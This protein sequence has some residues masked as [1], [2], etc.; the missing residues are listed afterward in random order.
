MTAR[1]ASVHAPLPLFMPQSTTPHHVADSHTTPGLTTAVIDE[2]ANPGSNDVEK[3]VHT[4]FIIDNIENLTTQML[5]ILIC[6]VPL[7]S[8][9]HSP[10]MK[11]VAYVNNN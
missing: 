5:Q 6:R 11:K 10:T 9:D 3:V 4:P 1:V 8:M 2:L 7:M